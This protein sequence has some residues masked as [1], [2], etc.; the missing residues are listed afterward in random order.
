DW[1]PA[2][3]GT[4]SHGLY[5]LLG[6]SSRFGELSGRLRRALRAN[7]RPTTGDWVAVAEARAGGGHAI[8]HQ[9]LERR[10][11]LKRRA[12]FS[13]TATQLVAANVERFFIVTSATNELN[14]RRLERYLTAVWDSGADPVL[15]LNKTD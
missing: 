1:V 13:D 7:A 12:A 9:V 14:Q 15:V 4:E 6:C 3:I 5:E 2:R 8:I 11:L 10:T